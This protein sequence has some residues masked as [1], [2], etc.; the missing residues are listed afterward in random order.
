LGGDA[1]TLGSSGTDSIANV[2]CVPWHSD[3]GRLLVDQEVE[4]PTV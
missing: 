2:V 3:A 4:S 1:L